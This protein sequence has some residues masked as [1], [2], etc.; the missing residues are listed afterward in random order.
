MTR[1]PAPLSTA[2]LGIGSNVDSRRNISSGIRTL[3]AEFGDVALSPVY[4]SVAVGFAGQDFLNLAARIQTAMQPLEL[5]E[6][7]NRLEDSHG[8]KRHLPKFS[9]RTLDIDI[10]L[11]DDLYLHTPAIDL[12]RPEILHYAH[13]LRPLADLAP[14]LK[15][16]VTGK[17]LHTH[18]Q[19]FDGHGAVLKPIDFT[20]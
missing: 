9:D 6:F 5:K 10:L 16:P 8:R 7:L 14:D 11:Y 17:T 2:Y 15:H 12:P 3:R 13:V 1:G 19:E 4:Q 20:A 18:W